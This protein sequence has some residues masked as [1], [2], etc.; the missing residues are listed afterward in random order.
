VNIVFAPGARAD[1]TEALA[2]WRENRPDAP[3]LMG[4]ELDRALRALPN[5]AQALVRYRRVEQL[6]V[7]RAHVPRVHRH[8]YFVLRDDDRLV[9]LA[10]WGAVRGLL[11]RLRQRTRTAI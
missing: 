1:I 5:V 3:D 10:V 7:R 8:I 4:T 6:D 2:W 11:P 9:V